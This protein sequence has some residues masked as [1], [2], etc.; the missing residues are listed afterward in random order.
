MGRGW[1]RSTV[2]AASLVALLGLGVTGTSS[3]SPPASGPGDVGAS[4][5]FGT[6]DGP[7][8]CQLANGIT[9]VVEIGFDNVHFFRDNPDVPSDM[10]MLPN[11]LN[12]LEDNGTVLSN[13]HTPLI[14]HTADDL[15]TTFTGL[16]GDRQGMPIANDYN[17]FNPNGTTDTAGSFAYWTDPVYDTTTAPNPGSDTNPN[18]VY[19]ATPPATTTP[20]P[21][22]DK[23]T[24]A[25]WV[26]FTRAG[27]NV[28]AVA[29]ANMELENTS[30]DIP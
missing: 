9:H 24:P 21:T 18:M 4:A 5:S 10:E 23:T 28:G 1:E 25:P 12:F 29:T 8:S 6:G 17:V 13:N 3:A 14:A 27:C 30:I 7:N 2:F 26:P 15:L 20:A 19:S 22:P 16:Y 11:L